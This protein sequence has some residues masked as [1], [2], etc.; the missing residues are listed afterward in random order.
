MSD[1]VG[2]GILNFGTFFV[3][4]TQIFLSRLRVVLNQLRLSVFEKSHI[5]LLTKAAS[6]P[7]LKSG[8]LT[9]KSV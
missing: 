5:I 4:E 7:K 8:T 2:D 6:L 1:A 9:P 3:A